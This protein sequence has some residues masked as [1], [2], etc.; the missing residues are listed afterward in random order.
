MPDTAI[1]VKNGGNEAGGRERG[2][3]GVGGIGVQT[4][5]LTGSVWSFAWI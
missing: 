2:V 4:A 1:A 3:W 5:E